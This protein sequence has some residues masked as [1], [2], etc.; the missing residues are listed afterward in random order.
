MISEDKGLTWKYSCPVAQ[1]EKGSFSETSLYETPKGDLVAFMRTADL[2]DHTCIARS[3]DHGKSFQQWQ[4]TGFQG[5]PHY[6]LRLPDSRVLLVY[7]YRHAPYGIRARVLNPECT[8]V[9]S[10]PEVVLRNDGGGVDIG[11]PWAAMISK[12][13]ALVVYYFNQQDTTRF[14]AGTV[15]DIQ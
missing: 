10:A 13:R 7:G 9:A 2:D 8:D 3:T 6:V 12:N 15:V 4:D 1:D 11:Y 5:H 14:I